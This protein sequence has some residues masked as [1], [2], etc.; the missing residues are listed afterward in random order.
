MRSVFVGVAAACAFVSPAW[1]QSPAIDAAPVKAPSAASV[2]KASPEMVARM[3]ALRDAYTS[4]IAAY[5]KAEQAFRAP[6]DAERAALSS[7][8]RTTS[9][10]SS[11]ALPRGGVA[12][13]GAASEVSFLVA[14]VNADGST[15]V[16]HAD[17]A[18]ER[19]AFARPILPQLTSKAAAQPS[20]EVR[21][22]E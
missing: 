7:S 10:S 12:L 22:A 6:S 18:P 11:V 13:R 9:A 3:Q 14:D 20:R 2:Q 4:R 8:A 15:V 17:S 21:H 5:D 16:R 1:A 19:P